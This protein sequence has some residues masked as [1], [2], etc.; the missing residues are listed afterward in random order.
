MYVVKMVVNVWDDVGV[1]VVVNVGVDV[2]GQ[3]RGRY[4]WSR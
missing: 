4:M 3:C 2:G 1:S